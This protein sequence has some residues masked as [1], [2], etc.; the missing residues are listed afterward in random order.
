MRFRKI[1]LHNFMRYKGD[2][3]LNF[4]CNPEKN[5]TIILGD[6]TF[7][8]TTIAQAFRWVLYGNVNKTNY[9]DDVKEITLL[10]NEVIASLRQ[11]EIADVKVELVVED[12]DKTYEFIRTQKFRKVYDDPGDLTVLPVNITPFLDMSV[13]GGGLISNAGNRDKNHPSGCVQK[14]I[15][16]MFPEKLSNYLFFDGERWSQ[17]KNKSEDIEKSIN[18]ILGI[19]SILKMTE[20]LKNG[21]SEYRTSVLTKLRRSVKGSTD[22]FRKT[23][24]AIKEID[25]KI[26]ETKEAIE[27]KTN[28][29]EMARQKAEELDEILNENSSMEQQQ[30]ELKSNE[31]NLI[32]EKGHARRYYADIINLLS[33]SDKFFTS[34]LLPRIEAILNEVD[35]EGKDIPGVTSDT[36]D[37]LLNNGV[38]LC[39]EKLEEGSSH[40]ETMIKLRQ[41][42]YPNKIG[43]PA[44]S[45]KLKLAN[46]KHDNSELVSEI[47]E[48]CR[49]YEDTQDDVEEIERNIENLER[50]IDRKLNLEDVRR[51][52]RNFKNRCNEC[53]TTINSYNYHLENLQ[54]EKD[55]L[56]KQL[57]G[58][59]KQD[60]E[61]AVVYRAIAY[62]EALFEKADY[63]VKARK[64]K[65]LE[66]LNALISDNYEK[67][68]N[69]N[70]KYAKLED[71][72]KMHMYYK[73]GGEEKNLSEGEVTAINFV[74]IVSILEL[75]KREKSNQEEKESVLSLP[76]VL[77]APFSKLGT[78][79]IGLISRKLPEFAEQVIIFML[80]K[81]WEASG[82]DK[83]TLDDYCYRVEREYSDVSSTIV[84]N[85]GVK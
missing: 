59:A 71:D 50:K 24:Y 49:D 25:K 40:Y 13:N 81:D 32:N 74:Y 57:D 63:N 83:Y 26:W 38:C 76:L 67:M 85:G 20:H 75:A 66:E 5:V 60:R 27:N 52:Y 54:K 69:S 1:K 48:K 61:N 19:S 8:K 23:E 4:S 22:E 55:S 35:I 9:V 41:D 58:I 2:N 46:W 64:S 68:F 77:D 21:N 62:A 12:G 37:W 33:K 53:E 11:N 44:K 42:V 10:N 45:L 43:G 73:A 31:K 6:N 51:K 56:T 80:D 82:L 79:N 34:E 65:T 72:Y 28:D 78:Q 36:I 7:G 70:E 29:L 84:G 39:G 30:K 16:E 14:T 18:I 15:E 17:T 47:R 3:E